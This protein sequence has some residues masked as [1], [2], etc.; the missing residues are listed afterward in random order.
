MRL[1]PE[2]SAG[3]AGGPMQTLRGR[4]FPAALG[5]AMTLVLEKKTLSN[6][7]KNLF[8]ILKIQT[9]HVAHKGNKIQVLLLG[10]IAVVR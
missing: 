5:Q 2:E 10:I 1:G 7:G 9:H 8:V 3:C 4:S 6:G